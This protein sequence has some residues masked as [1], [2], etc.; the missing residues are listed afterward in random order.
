MT[1]TE[2]IEVSLFGGIVIIGLPAIMLA[3]L[4]VFR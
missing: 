3:T 1:M 4:L 2:R